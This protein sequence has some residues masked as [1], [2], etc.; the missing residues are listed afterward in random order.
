MII[1]WN[2]LIRKLLKKLKKVAEKTNVDYVCSGKTA[3][4]LLPDR[5]MFV[6]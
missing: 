1:I 3:N 4:A 6:I 2:D 5:Y